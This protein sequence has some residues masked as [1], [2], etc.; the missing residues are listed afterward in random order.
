VEDISLHIMDIIENSIT[1]GASE[2][3]VRIDR[4]AKDVLEFTITD[5]GNGM[6]EEQRL[7]ALDPF[8][9]TKV[10]KRVGLGLALFKQSAEET[11]G[12][13]DVQSDTGEGTTV[14]A[15]FHTDHPDMKPLGDIEDTIALLGVCHPDIEFFL[16]GVDD[17]AKT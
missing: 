4:R 17:E 10:G 5:N 14:R 1:G 9:T 3:R 7:K 8:Y 12:S 11:E 15:V 6:K 2:I 13:F 16:E